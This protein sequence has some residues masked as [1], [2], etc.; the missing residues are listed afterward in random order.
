MWRD[1]SKAVKKSRDCKVRDSK[2]QRRRQQSLKRWQH[3]ADTCTFKPETILNATLWPRRNIEVC[4]YNN[5]K[6]PKIIH[7]LWLCL[8]VWLLY[9][10]YS[11]D[12][13]DVYSTVDGC[14][15]TYT[16]INN[17]TRLTSDKSC[18]QIGLCHKLTYSLLYYNYR[19][20]H[21]LW[22]MLETSH[23][24]ALGSRRLY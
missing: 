21:R 24:Y 5:T 22:S 7:G 14:L 2:L 10:V 15:T 8:W 11:T 16:V 19:P 18:R 23:Y 12:Y 9:T 13:V 6:D 1:E 20:W 4:G 3:R 17:W